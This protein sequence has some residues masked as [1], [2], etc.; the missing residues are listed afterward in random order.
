MKQD[1]YFE[2]GTENKFTAHSAVL[3]QTKAV[4]KVPS[5]P[6]D[7]LLEHSCCITNVAELRNA[8]DYAA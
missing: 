5:I 2:S 6:E 4:L 7:A 3:S 8:E 1:R